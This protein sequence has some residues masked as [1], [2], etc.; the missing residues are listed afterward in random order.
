MPTNDLEVSIN[1]FISQYKVKIHIGK[2]KVHINNI[3]EGFQYFND[4]ISTNNITMN[5]IGKNGN[6]YAN[7][8][9]IGMFNIYGALWDL[10]ESIIWKHY[11]E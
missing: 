10:D 4:Y 3:Q 11:H 2:K 5:N 6:L 9:L 8:V 1:E 7:G